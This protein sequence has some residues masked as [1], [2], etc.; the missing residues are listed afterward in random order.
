M[1]ES[2][3]I[4]VTNMCYQCQALYDLCPDCL[5][6]KDARDIDIAH[7]IVDEGNLQYRFVWSQ[8]ETTV[9]NHDWVGSITKLRRPAILADGS[10]VEERYEFLDPI[11]LLADRI[12]DLETSL[13]VTDNETVCEQCHY[14][15]NK[16]I[17][18]P[19]CN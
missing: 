11:S 18:C 19:N 13:T 15:H 9:S 10:K 14:L 4:S 1:S 17:A 6:L 3:G 12:I 8:T 2:N 5:E 7:Q 16:A